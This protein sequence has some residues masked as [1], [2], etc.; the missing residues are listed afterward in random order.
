M[1]YVIKNLQKQSGDA[2]E[3]TQYYIIMYVSQTKN[4]HIHVP[5]M[6]T[7]MHTH[8]YVYI[9]YTH[10]HIR[11]IYTYACVHNS[12]ICIHIHTQYPH[13]ILWDFMFSWQCKDAFYGI[14]CM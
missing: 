7:C 10:A 9:L 8:V 14:L 4:A 12:F 1:V 13:D 3:F 11:M 5:Y 6:H 2:Q